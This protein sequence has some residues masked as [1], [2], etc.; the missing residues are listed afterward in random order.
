MARR[1]DLTVA[2]DILR[3]ARKGARKTTLV[4]QAN[5]N[6]RVIDRYLPRLLDSKMLE[7]KGPYF[8]TTEKGEEYI[9]RIKVLTEG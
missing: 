8:Y 2:A 1:N 3:V 7:S 9:E 4:Y 6:F 5:L